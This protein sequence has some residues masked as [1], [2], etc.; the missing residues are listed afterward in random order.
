MEGSP[1]GRLIIDTNS[2][3]IIMSL[4]NKQIILYEAYLTVSKLE[5]VQGKALDGKK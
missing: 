3:L 2:F 4:T 1:S 5:R